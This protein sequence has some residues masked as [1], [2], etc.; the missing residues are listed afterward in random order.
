[1]ALIHVILVAYIAL[2]AY[3]AFGAFRLDFAARAYERRRRRL[4]AFMWPKDL[5]AYVVVYRLL[6]L[7]SLAASVALYV[8]FLVK[9]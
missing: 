6:A 8:F 4:A 5:K 2:S 1:M 9:Y 7:A 3:L